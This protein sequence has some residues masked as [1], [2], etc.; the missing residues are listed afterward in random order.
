MRGRETKN[1]VASVLARLRNHAKSGGTPFQQVLQQYAIERFLYRISKSKH[2]ESVVLKGALLLKT[3]GIPTA[4]PT[5]DIDML[6]RG[7]ADQVTLMGLVRDCAVLEVE[8]DGLMFLADS[9]VAE[10]ITK[11]SEY[12]GTRI[13][14]D[15]RMD[16][17]RLRIQVDFGVGDVMVPGPRIVECIYPGDW[18]DRN[19]FPV[20]TVKILVLEATQAAQSGSGRDLLITLRFHVADQI[21]VKDF[22]HDNSIVGLSIT[23]RARGHYTDGTPLPPDLLVT[24]QPGFGV[25][26]HFSCARIEVIGAEWANGAS[27]GNPTSTGSATTE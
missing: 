13:L 9:V 4:R 7:K 8:S 2:A 19:V 24:F 18:D 12:K 5:M 1:V 22:N 6:R 11:D 16:N 27:L 3:I 17:V 26:A 21:T 20:I 10:E 14:M 15:A 23:E 25:A